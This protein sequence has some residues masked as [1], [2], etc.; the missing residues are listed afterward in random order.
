[1]GLKNSILARNRIGIHSFRWR[2]LVSFTILF[3]TEYVVNTLDACKPLQKLR[4]TYC[5]WATLI[6]DHVLMI[7]SV[8]P[9]VERTV[10]KSL[11]HN[12][13]H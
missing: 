3:N 10:K 11:E 2:I 5:S 7:N 13:E 4:D 1:M 6:K 8:R 12:I 9:H